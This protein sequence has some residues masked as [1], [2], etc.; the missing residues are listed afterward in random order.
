MIEGWIAELSV[1]TAKRTDDDFTE[2]LRLT[3]Y[4][5]R[6]QHYPADIVAEALLRHTWKFFPSWAELK[7]VLEDLHRPRRAIINKLLSEA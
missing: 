2:S 5:N 7:D 3:A 1:I 4:T 6:L